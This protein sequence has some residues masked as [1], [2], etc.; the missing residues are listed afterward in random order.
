VNRIEPT[1]NLE[2]EEFEAP[3]DKHNSPLEL[4][5]TEKR[6]LNKLA[7]VWQREVAQTIDFLISFA[8]FALCLNISNALQLEGSS[9]EILIILIPFIYYAFSDGFPKGQSIGKRLFNISVIDKESGEYCTFLKSF[10]RNAFTPITGILDVLII[11]FKRRRRLGDI[12]AGTIVV[13]NS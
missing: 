11:L 2:Q 3:D 9:S 5:F 6:K 10:L 12:F 7:D 1:I 8:I 13:K 4:S